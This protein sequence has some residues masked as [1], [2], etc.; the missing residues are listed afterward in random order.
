MRILIFIVY[1]LSLNSMEILAQNLV[2]NPSF[3]EYI[4]CPTSVG[5]LGVQ[6][7]G[8]WVQDWYPASLD[9]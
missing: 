6:G 1:L 8:M 4:T 2:P 5:G 9:L 3:E 7:G